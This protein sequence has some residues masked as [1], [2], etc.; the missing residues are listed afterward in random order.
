MREDTLSEINRIRQRM[1]TELAR[2]TQRRRNFKTGRGGVLD[3]E[4]IVQALQL[5][6]GAQ[7]PSLLEVI[8]TELHLERLAEL[9]LLD[10][11]AAGVLRDGWRFLGLLSS[12]LRIVDNRSISDLDRERGDLESLARSLGYTSPGREGGARRA[13]LTDYERHTSA[14]RAEYQKV[15]QNV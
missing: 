15:F 5:T 4:S 13:L 2:E 1:E 12:R 3:V 7:H 6:Y 10:S 11:D 8:P 9:E 14:I